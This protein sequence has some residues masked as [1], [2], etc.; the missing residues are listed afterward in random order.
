MANE[1]AQRP[2]LDPGF[3]KFP[4]EWECPITD[5]VVP[6]NPDENLAYRADI[7]AEAE[8]DLELQRELYTACSKSL[9]YFIN[10]FGWTK[11]VF[12]IED[13]SATPPEDIHLPYVTWPIQDKHLLALENA[14]DTGKSLLTDKSRDMGATWDHIIFYVHRFIFRQDESHLLLSR[15]ENTVDILDGIPKNYPFG[16]LADPGTLFGKIDYALNRLPKW[17][18][19]KMNRKKLHL[20]NLDN[21]SRID[22]ESANA[23]A[24][25][26]DRRN[27]I[28]MDEMAKMDEGESI[29]RST[30]AVTA[31]RF[32]CSTPNGAGT[33]YSEWR[34][35]G[36]IPVFIMPW[37]EH[38][39]KGKNRYVF[40]DELQ[41]FKIRSP[42]YD[43]ECEECTAKEIAIEVDMDHVGSGNTVFDPTTLTQ[44]KQV[45]GADALHKRYINFKKGVPDSDV[46]ALLSTQKKGAMS[47]V[48][49]TPR[50]KW[51]IW[52]Q[53]INGRPDQTKTYTAGVDIS[54]GQGASNSVIS[55]ICDQTKMK[56]AEFADANI[57]PFELAKVTCAA[58]IWFGG[59]KQMFVIW[60]NNGDPGLGFGDQLMSTYKYP[61]VYYDRA[62]GTVAKK[63]GKRYGW[64]SDPEKKAVV[65]NSLARAYEHGGFIN[66]SEEALDEALMYIRYDGGGIGPAILL[67]ESV[68]ARA[69]HGDRVIADMLCVWGSADRGKLANKPI[70]TG[71]AYSIGGRMQRYRRLRRQNSRSKTFDFRIGAAS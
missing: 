71:A 11:R 16:P 38:P 13:G 68:Q 58:S 52:C 70:R 42:W 64:R 48:A 40:E 50:G 33:A 4:D 31:T 22:G 6:K 41:R 7:L 21:K 36:Q 26:S 32:P 9:L 35:S 60:E 23:T 66:P 43:K 65:I 47:K 12:E 2:S 45:F 39:E 30:R 49:V 67:K 14:L 37:W 8:N 29:K 24:G 54:K 51:R 62:K 69:T 53:L 5:L 18:L 34:M 61:S 19:P 3:P 20:V 44:H 15:K 25:S 63:V 59:A 17:M 28:F 57:K 56:V 10:A 55:I 27:S 46:P 1:F